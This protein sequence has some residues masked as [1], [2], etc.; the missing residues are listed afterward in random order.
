VWLTHIHTDAQPFACAD[1]AA[2]V[3]PFVSHRLQRLHAERLLRRTRHGQ[4][5]ALVSHSIDHLMGHNEMMLR[6]YHCLH[7]VP[8]QRTLAHWHGATI[9]IG[10]RQLR[11]ATG[12]QLPLNRFVL[13]LALPQLLDL[14][15]QFLCAGGFTGAL[16]S[17]T[18]SKSCR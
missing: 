18:W 4:Q 14:G 17:S 8:D 11:F 16:S 12:F 7:V 5:L 1:L 2:V 13:C 3:I 6:V 9:G 15:A 10:L